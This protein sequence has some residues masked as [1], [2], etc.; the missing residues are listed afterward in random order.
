MIAAG[1]QVDKWVP[2]L[3]VC[4]ESG[5]PAQGSCRLG[6]EHEQEAASPGLR[7]P[8]GAGSWP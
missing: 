2:P 8:Q 3:L 1:F 4:M 7:P 5:L 6:T